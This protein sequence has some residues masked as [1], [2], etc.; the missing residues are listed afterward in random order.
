MGTSCNAPQIDGQSASRPVKPRGSG[1]GK[2]DDYDVVE[3]IDLTDVSPTEPLC[4]HEE[5]GKDVTTHEEE[6]NGNDSYFRPLNSG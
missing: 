4:L 5:S 2:L 6:A 1:S 3:V